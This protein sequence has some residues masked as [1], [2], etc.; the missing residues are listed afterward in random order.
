MSND[1]KQIGQRLA[2]L[3]DAL[4]LSPEEF[5]KACDIPLEEYLKFENGEK[6]LTISILRR[7]AST[8]NVD[9]SVLMFDEEPRMNSYFLTRKGKGLSVK[10]VEDYQYQS[11]AGNFNNKKADIFEVTVEPKNDGVEIH[12][13]THTGQ[14]FNLVVE[15]RM[16][17]QINGKDLILNEGDSLFFDST[18]PHGMKALDGKRVRFIAVVM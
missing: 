11:L 1:P 8:Y 17:L 4:E 10:R 16:L 6:D 18:L 9:V 14:E 2:G 15:G 12:H 13:S 3:R 5:A 7:I